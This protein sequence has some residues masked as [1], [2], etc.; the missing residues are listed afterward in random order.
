MAEKSE[1]KVYKMT[2]VESYSTSFGILVG[3]GIISMT[4]IAIGYTGSGVWLAYILAGIICLISHG[5]LLLAA[6]V[7]PKTS[8]DYF[9]CKVVGERMGGMYAYLFLTRGISVSFYGA[10]FVSY[11]LSIVDTSIDTRIL[12][13]LVLGVF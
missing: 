8:G 2:F 13:L 11:L 10:S 9:Y 4:G 12:I 6:S 7:V 1:S 5:P 3:S